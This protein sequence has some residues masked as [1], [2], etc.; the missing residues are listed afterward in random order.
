MSLPFIFYYFILVCLHIAFIF[1]VPLRS[2]LLF[3]G[4]RSRNSLPLNS[5][6]QTRVTPVFTSCACSHHPP[7]T[8]TT[9]PIYNTLIFIP[10]HPPL[11]A[12]PSIKPSSL[13][14]LCYSTPPPLSLLHLV[15]GLAW[16]RVFGAEKVEGGGGV[17]DG[18]VGGW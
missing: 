18:G 4:Q 14:G 9:S 7:A 3:D 17:A 12:H 1:F 16:V 5:D 2:S 6:E 15:G 11:L 10:F 13:S 8:P